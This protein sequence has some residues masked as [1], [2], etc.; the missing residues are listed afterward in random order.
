MEYCK[1]CEELK[2]ITKKGYD[3]AYDVV[4]FLHDE[5]QAEKQINRKLL[6][7]LK[8]NAVI[9]DFVVE[10]DRIGVQ[11]KKD[12]SEFLFLSMTK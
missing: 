9:H 7:M 11:A 4:K 5:L 2:E 3:Q 6:E 12:V 1:N 8:E 10:Q